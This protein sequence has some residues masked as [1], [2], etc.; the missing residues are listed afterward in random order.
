MT[1]DMTRGVPV[2]CVRVSARELDAMI[3]ELDSLRGRL[4]LLRAPLSR[5]LADLAAI[6][7]AALARRPAEGGAP[8]P[9]A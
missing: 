6:G 4:P 2:P 9:R 5:A 1:A 8:C 7:R 3:R